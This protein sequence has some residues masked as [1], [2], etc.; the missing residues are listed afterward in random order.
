MAPPLDVVVV[1]PVDVEVVP[2]VGVLVVPPVFVVLAPP[3]V[4]VVP[5]V[6]GP[7]SVGDE[8]CTTSRLKTTPA[9]NSDLR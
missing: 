8:Q 2:P 7:V 9:I 6:P 5:P 3:D 4:A 1:P